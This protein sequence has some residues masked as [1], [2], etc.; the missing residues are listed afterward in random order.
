MYEGYSYTIT[1]G[2]STISANGYC[3][4]EYVYPG[5][6]VRYCSLSSVSYS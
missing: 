2:A 6:F 3:L 4:D 5:P 1:P